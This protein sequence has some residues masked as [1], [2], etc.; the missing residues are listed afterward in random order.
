MALDLLNGA[1]ESI[2]AAAKSVVLSAVLEKSMQRRDM[3]GGSCDSIAQFLSR[4][5]EP[6]VAGGAECPEKLA[7]LRHR[8]GSKVGEDVLLIAVNDISLGGPL[9]ERSPV[10]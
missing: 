8:A 1:Q 4:E 7:F 6:A 9:H 3:R 5:H 2:A 10:V